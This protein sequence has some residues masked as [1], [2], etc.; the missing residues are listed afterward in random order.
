MCRQRPCRDCILF[1][2]KAG[3]E[4]H[5]LLRVGPAALLH[6][7]VRPLKLASMPAAVLCVLCIVRRVRFLELLP[8][9]PIK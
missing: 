5:L 9:E 3:R 6:G 4:T 2:P 8:R 7:A 1:F